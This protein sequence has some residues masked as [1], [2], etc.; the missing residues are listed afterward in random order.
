VHLSFFARVSGVM[1]CPL[2]I[3]SSFIDWLF[4]NRDRESLA[5]LHHHPP[6]VDDLT[7]NDGPT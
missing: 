2:I 6:S 4:T 7:A 5:L 1:S 3:W